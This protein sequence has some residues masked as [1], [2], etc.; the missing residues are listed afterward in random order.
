[1]ITQIHI[2]YERLFY[3]GKIHAKYLTCH[4]LLQY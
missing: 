2:E 3:H 1:M 4:T